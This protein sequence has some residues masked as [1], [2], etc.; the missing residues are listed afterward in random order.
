[1]APSDELVIGVSLPKTGRYAKSA[2][3]YYERAYNLW[4]DE[5]NRRGGLLGKRVRFLIYDDGSTPEN[6]AENYRRLI[7]DDNVPLLL[8]PCHSVLVEA[9]APV[10]EA[11]RRLLLQGSGSS[12]EIFEKNRKYLF[13]CWS[14]CDFD[15]PKSFLELMA[16]ART[17]GRSWI[18]ALACT[19]GRIGRAVAL[20]AKHYAALH[21]FEI[22]HEEMI[23]KP[24]FDYSGLMQRIKAKNADVVLIGLDHTRAD[25]P[26]HSC[27]VEAQKAG[28]KPTR[29]WLSDN[30]SAENAE[31]GAAIDGVFMRAT[32]IPLDPD[33]LSRSFA[34]AF[35][36]AYGAE[37]EYHSAGG[38]A[39]CQV[40]EQTVRTTGNLQN[41]ALRETLL[42]QSF[43]TVMGKLRFGANGLSAGAMKL[44]QWQNGNLAI[45]YPDS[46]RTSQPVL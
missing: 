38:Y 43:T 28:L 19:D 9:A 42:R 35:K 3:V 46:D 1:M 41:E 12:H 20:G 14:G 7:H 34:H 22:A 17:P 10:V 45:V 13:L 4:L 36:S 27:I 21:G 8:G 44:C 32:W 16:R 5:I 18:A 24:P 11:A 29:L 6:A 33:P 40:L 30:P 37:P 2:C 39:G 23:S 25:K 15:Y 31:L 26:R